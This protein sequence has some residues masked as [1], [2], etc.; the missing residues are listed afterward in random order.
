MRHLPR[1]GQQP[2][3]RLPPSLAGEG[4]Q[5]RAQ[6]SRAV[7]PEAVVP[8]ELGQ[9]AGQDGVARLPVGERPG[10]AGAL[11]RRRRDTVGQPG[12]QRPQHRAGV[13]SG[14][15][16]VEDPEGQ[17]GGPRRR[18]VPATHQLGEG[19][20]AGQGDAALQHEIGGDRNVRGRRGR[21]PASLRR[22]HVLAVAPDAIGLP[23]LITHQQQVV[24]VSTGGVCQAI[25]RGLQG[26]HVLLVDVARLPLREVVAHD[27]EQDRPR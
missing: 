2:P 25:G 21:S 13:V 1:Q 10:D 8:A 22:R 26:E 4:G 23:P 3:D 7:L 24:H 12:R 15:V 18:L 19:R 14:R 6:V 16:E 11:A 20:P 27:G 9:P 5:P 17:G